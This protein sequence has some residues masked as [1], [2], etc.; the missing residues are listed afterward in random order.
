VNLDDV[1]LSEDPHNAPD[2]TET[3]YRELGYEILADGP[4]GPLILEK[5]EGELQRVH[6]LFH[7]DRSTLVYRV[8]FPV[9]ITNLV[10]SAMR[11]AQLS[12][13]AAATTWCAATGH[14]P[15]RAKRSDRR[16]G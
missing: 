6:L 5:S 14:T 4:H 13:V 12:E 9:L 8:G 1:V 2:V 15:S 11:R 3:R 10:Q 16:S 7:P